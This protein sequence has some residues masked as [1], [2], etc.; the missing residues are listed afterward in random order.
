MEAKLL[1]K[2]LF[3][4]DVPIVFFVNHEKYFEIE[5]KLNSTFSHSLIFYDRIL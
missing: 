1:N 3:L 5:S 2:S 4:I